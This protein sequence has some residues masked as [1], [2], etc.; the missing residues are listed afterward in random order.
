MNLFLEI[1]VVSM[2]IGGL[3]YFIFDIDF[4]KVICISIFPIMLIALGFIMGIGI[5]LTNVV[6]GW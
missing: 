3:C 1:I 4:K 2:L 6:F 5:H